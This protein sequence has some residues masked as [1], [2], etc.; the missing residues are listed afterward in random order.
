MNLPGFVST[1]SDLEIAG[2]LW[3]P[4]IG[5][6]VSNRSEPENIS[7]LVNTGGLTPTQLRQAYIWLPS[8]EQLVL[9]FEARQAILFHAGLELTKHNYCYKTVV[10]SPKGPIECYAESL[11]GA[12]ARALCDLL[13]R[14]KEGSLH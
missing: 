5:D 11:R 14:F 9:Q 2:L 4:E 7:V 8:V 6:E 10:Q 1:A 3:Q 12:L 13:L